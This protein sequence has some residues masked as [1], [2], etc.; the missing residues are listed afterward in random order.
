MLCL[1][2]AIDGARR[3]TRVR[4]LDTMRSVS[5]GR[6][7]CEFGR[8]IPDIRNY[9]SFVNLWHNETTMASPGDLASLQGCKP[10]PIAR[11][12][13]AR[14]RSVL[15]RRTAGRAYSKI[16]CVLKYTK[17]GW[18][19]GSDVVLA[20]VNLQPGTAHAP[21]S[22]S[23]SRDRIQPAKTYNVK[24]SHPPRRHIYVGDGRSG[25]ISRPTVFMWAFRRSRNGGVHRANS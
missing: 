11:D 7:A 9:H 23:M 5:S 18:D 15:S 10:G 21:R 25:W 14:A 1:F 20:F 8:P 2:C 13:A 24:N 16:F 12:G 19:Q 6:G 17:C 4:S 3:C 22:M